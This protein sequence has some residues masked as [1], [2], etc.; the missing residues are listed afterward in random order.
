MKQILKSEIMALALVMLILS[1]VP[2]GIWVYDHHL[3]SRKIPAN[4]KVFTLSAHTDLGWLPG[5]VRGFDVVRLDK[6]GSAVSKPVLRVNQG[7][8]VV[9]KLTSSDVIHGFSLKDYGIFIEDGIRPGK[10]TLVSF[11]ADKAGTFTFSCNII[12]G[13]Q[14]KKMQGVIEVL[15]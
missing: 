8:T 12:C 2:A 6:G 9:L 5:R 3:W 15:A 10:V 7:D 14:H 11:K 13:D 1:G 4:A